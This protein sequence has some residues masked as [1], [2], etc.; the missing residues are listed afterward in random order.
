MNPRQV[1][2]LSCEAI[3]GPWMIPKALEQITSDDILAL[4]ANKEPERRTLDFKRDLPGTTDADRREL[5]ADMTSFANANGGDLVFGVDEANGVAVAVP[6]LEVSDIDAAIRQIE[7][8]VQSGVDPRIPGFKSHEVSMPDTGP[9]IVVRVPRSWRG[10]HLVRINDTFRMYGRNSKGKY[11]FDAT[12]IRSA[13]SLADELPQR[14]RRWRDDRLAAIIGGA[15][16]VP[17][18]PGAKLIVHLVPLESLTSGSQVSVESMK[19]FGQHF[20]PLCDSGGRSRINIDGLVKSAGWDAN[21]GGA[22]AYCQVF[23]SG[24]VEAVSGTIVQGGSHRGAIGSQWI[25]DEVV[26]C[27]EQYRIG[28]LGCGVSPPYLILS[29]LSGAQGAILAVGQRLG[30]FDQHPV[31]RDL[32]VLPEVLLETHDSEMRSALRP[33]F[34]GLWNACGWERCFDYAP[35]GEW[36][37]K[38]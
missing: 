15:S 33:I 37:P 10:P 31:D 36:A 35:G 3:R 30:A 18:I 29:A 1:M 24:R 21:A 17:L 16:P 13:F 23:R 12:E 28:L 20:P 19:A 7:Q 2:Q 26:E 38:R 34:D 5:R 32:V 22:E 6:G 8:T 25:V 27:V 11:I 4:V 9:V 14:V